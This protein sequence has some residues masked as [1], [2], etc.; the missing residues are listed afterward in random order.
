MHTE[1]AR[2]RLVVASGSQGSWCGKLEGMAY[3]I[4]LGMLVNSS[5]TSLISKSAASGAPMFPA[6]VE[7]GKED[8]RLSES[9]SPGDGP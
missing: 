8:T 3:A 4:P 9:S 1:R 7:E 5:S 2:Q 6:K